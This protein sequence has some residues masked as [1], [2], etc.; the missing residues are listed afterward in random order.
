MS[1][2]E[3][4][5]LYLHL[6]CFHL[7]TKETSLT[8]TETNINLHQTRDNRLYIERMQGLVEII[9]SVWVKKMRLEFLLQGS[10]TKRSHRKYVKNSVLINF[11]VIDV[12]QV[13]RWSLTV[14]VRR[15]FVYNK[16]PHSSD[17]SHNVSS[18][19]LF[20][21]NVGIRDRQKRPKWSQSHYEKSICGIW[22][23]ISKARCEEK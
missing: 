2:D 13:S 10:I 18:C 22:N 12:I 16:L 15:W 6:E 17:K 23:N 14:L 19:L 7:E 11:H 20:V 21:L 3:D 4:G 8:V 1:N 5:H 9:I